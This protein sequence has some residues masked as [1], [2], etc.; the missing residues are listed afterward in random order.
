M[1]PSVQRKCFGAESIQKTG[2]IDESACLRALCIGGGSFLACSGNKGSAGCRATVPASASPSCA[3]ASL[4]LKAW[5]MSSMVRPSGGSKAEGLWLSSVACRAASSRAVHCRSTGW[6][7][8]LWAS[9]RTSLSSAKLSCCTR[10]RV[11]PPLQWLELLVWRRMSRRRRQGLLPSPMASR[12]AGLVLSSSLSAP[13]GADAGQM[14]LSS[15]EGEES[16]CRLLA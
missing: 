13:A 15:G 5:I 2:L 8:Y 1:Q 9:W 11:S 12:M 6:M 3:V 7:S 4:A 10:L 16:S 14:M